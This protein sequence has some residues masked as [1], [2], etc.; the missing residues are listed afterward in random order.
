[1]ELLKVAFGLVAVIGTLSV[2]AAAV[3]MMV[4]FGAEAFSHS[5]MM[6]EVGSCPSASTTHV[7]RTGVVG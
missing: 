3:Y 1:M 4:G 2:P 7:E 6:R 5:D